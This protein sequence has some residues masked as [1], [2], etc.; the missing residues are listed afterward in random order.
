MA[1]VFVSSLPNGR[2]VITRLGPRPSSLPA[3]VSDADWEAFA[4]AKTRFELTRPKDGQGRVLNP[5][6]HFDSS[7]PAH[8]N[9]GNGLSVTEMDD[10][11]LP[12]DRANR[13]N[14]I[15]QGNRVVV[16]PTPLPPLEDS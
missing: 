16:S 12:T 11:D 9:R 13:T 8:I 2:A 10:V 7:N 1:K 6:E 3:T 5:S 14:W 15:R 4:L